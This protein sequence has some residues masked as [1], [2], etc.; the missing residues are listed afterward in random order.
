MKELHKKNKR[1]KLFNLVMLVL[2]Y[3]F[4]FLLF[5][6]TFG[7]MLMT[8]GCFTAMFILNVNYAVGIVVTLYFLVPSDFLAYM[9]VASPFGNLPL[10]IIFM[11]FFI[12]I[13]CVKS[14]LKRKKC[15]VGKNEFFV[16]SSLILL[17]ILQMLNFVLRQNTEILSNSVKFFF[18]TFGMLLLVKVQNLSDNDRY[19][20]YLYIL[21]LI[22]ATIGVAIAEMF[23]DL[24]I[25]DIYGSADYSEQYNWAMS[26]GL[27]WRAKSTFVNPLVYGSTM[28]MCLP[29]ID[30]L[31]KRSNKVLFILGSIVILVIGMALS[32]SRSAIIISCVFIIYYI[33]TSNI[34]Q[35][36]TLVIP[37]II[38]AF[39]MVSNLDN[40]LILNRFLH[41]SGSGS[42]SH[43]LESYKIFGDIFMNNPFIGTGLGNSYKILQKYVGNAFLTNTFDNA[44]MDY[45]MAVGG[46]GFMLTI[47]SVVNALKFIQKKNLKTSILA[48]DIFVL[49]SFFLN[50]TKYQ[51][52]WGLLWIYI[53][54]DM[55]ANTQS[56]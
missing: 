34:K 43:R 26:S 40:T 53:A 4:I 14:L 16:F 55:Y 50:T 10:Y 9:F 11:T 5:K 2:C 48:V 29:V 24:N 47:I 25:Y 20:I 1:K 37:C 36:L 52:I 54:V 28:V 49:L 8:L 35:K 19:N 13:G 30:F 56:K 23:F 45:S 3:L 17:F 32:G 42:V 15:V 27:S 51:S 39:V 31:R 38:I 21:I 44:F 6:P 46:I 22:F 12:C 33:W 18:Q 41:L 7:I